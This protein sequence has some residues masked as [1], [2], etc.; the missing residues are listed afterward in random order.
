MQIGIRLHDIEPGTL[1]QRVMRAHEQGFTCGHLALAKT[2]SE[3]SVANSALTPGYAA[4][5]RKM[6]AKYDVDIAVLGCYLNLAHPDPEEL[7]KIQ[8][9]YF[10][11]IR[12]ASIL[13]CSVVGTE[14]GAPNADYHFEPACH[15]EEALQT[16]IANVRPVVECAEKFGVILAIEPVW[17]HIVYDSKQ[18]L[19]VLKEIHSP[20]LQII[21]DPVNLLSVENCGEYESV[22]AQAIEDLGEYTA[23]LHMKDFVVKDHTIVSGAPGTGIMKYDTIMDFVRKEKPYI[24]MT[25]EDST[26]ENAVESRKFLERFEK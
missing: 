20:N 25:I 11:H 26:P 6:F 5:L 18:A 22:F 7:K 23:V 8:E 13:G 15:T 4:Y 19:R 1:E 9:R 2:V 14:T 24:Q 3:H 12:F 10:A 21:L 17:S 16:F